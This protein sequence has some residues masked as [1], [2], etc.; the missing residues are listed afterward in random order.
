MTHADVWNALER[1][2]LD[3]VAERLNLP[4]KF[5]FRVIHGGA[6][7]A[8]TASGEWA[9]SEGV[10]VTSY[11]ANWKKH[12]KAAG[13]IR[14]RQMIEEGKPDIVVA[15]P[16]GRGTAN[17]IAQAEERGIPVVK[18]NIKRMEATDE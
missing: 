11:P 3:A 16:G 7:G 1:D 10:K 6:L 12:G 5:T 15:L 18:I 2:C 17:M 9:K 8:D 13:P 4:H 14:N